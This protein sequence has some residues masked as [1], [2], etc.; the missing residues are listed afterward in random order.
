MCSLFGEVGMTY[1]ISTAP[2]LTTTRSINSSI[3]CRFCSKLA[4]SRPFC[5]RRQKSTIVVTRPFISICCFTLPSHW[6]AWLSTPARRCSISGR[7]RVYSSKVST[8]AKYASVNRSNCPCKLVAARRKFSCRACNSC[9][10]P[11][12]LVHVV[13]PVLSIPGA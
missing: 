1:R 5:M 12:P 6:R 10:N 13:M 9:G 7:R 2:S 8:C 11:A 3:N 4:A